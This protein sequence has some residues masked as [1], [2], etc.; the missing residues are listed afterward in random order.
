MAAYNREKLHKNAQ[1]YVASGKIEN[2]I[3]EYEKILEQ[4]PLDQSILNTVGDLY[5]MLKRPSS[6][7]V[8]FLRAAQRLID[9]GFY[10]KAL[11][12]YRKIVRAEPSNLEYAETL[13]DLLVKESSAIEARKQYSDVGAA[14]I[15]A[16]NHTRAFQVYKKLADMSQDDPAP[17]LKL[18]ELNVKQG[19]REAARDSYTMAGN[20]AFRK[21]DFSLALDA[22][23]MALGI[24]ASYASAL[25]ILFKIAAEQKNFSIALAPLQAAAN[26][27]PDAADI[28]EM[29]SRSLM[30]TGDISKAVPIFYRLF[31]QDNNRYPL[32]LELAQA[33]IQNEDLA[34]ASESLQRIG[35]MLVERKEHPRLVTLH[36]AILE[37]DPAYIPSLRALA[38][39]YQATS[40]NFNLLEITENLADAL[41]AAKEHSEALSIL[42][43]LLNWEPQNEKFQRM[44]RDVFQ[45]LY[46]N[47]TYT[48]IGI[49]EPETE[50]GDGLGFLTAASS[51]RLA[52]PVGS[53]GDAESASAIE[54]E[55]F[56]SYGMRDKAKARLLEKIQE[57]PNDVVFRRKLIDLLKEEGNLKEAADLCFELV[58]LYTLK[59]EH[60]RA[61]EVMDEGLYLDPSRSE[62]SL[63]TG[64]LKAGIQLPMDGATA[65]LETGVIDLDEDAIDLTEDLA[66]IFVGEEEKA[67]LP[68]TPASQTGK[69]PSGVSLGGAE[70]FFLLEDLGGEQPA[71]AV[72]PPPAPA[73]ARP[74]KKG[75]GELP[76]RKAPAPS[77]PKMDTD[78]NVR[79]QEAL[80]SIGPQ[81]SGPSRTKAPSPTEQIMSRLSEL[82]PQEE[83]LA[84]EIL[85]EAA[86]AT[87]L[88]DMIASP[89]A[90]PPGEDKFSLQVSLKEADFYIK[91]GF[92]DN[93]LTELNKLLAKYPGNPEILDRIQALSGSAAPAPS[94]PALLEP[95][96]E[97]SELPPANL[98]P[99][100]SMTSEIASADITPEDV[101]IDLFSAIPADSL[102]EE[103]EGPSST[104]EA[105]NLPP[106][107]MPTPPP[108]SDGVFF[109]PESLL[110]DL[111]E[112]EDRTAR[113]ESQGLF[114]PEEE[115]E[116]E[117]S[118]KENVASLHNMFSDIAEEAANTFFPASAEEEG[119]FDT[120]Y[121]MGIVF[122]DMDLYDDA[123]REFQ[124]AFNFVKNAPTTPDFLQTCHMLSFCFAEKG[125]HKS[126]IKW[127][128]RAL[129]TPGHQDHEYMALKYDMAVCYEK[130]GDSL[131][132]MDLYTEIYELDVNYRDV[133]GKINALRNK[134]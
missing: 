60:Q 125:L 69:Q 106:A 114:L 53:T 15:R 68:P 49:Q 54:I 97:I 44:H 83:I 96:M 7:L 63:P 118:S 120:H 85:E 37:K 52:S 127:C 100:L 48:P 39:I 38:D 4:E 90:P 59:G 3:K 86:E 94:E 78:L 12:I 46:P 43:K 66:E 128:E 75:T 79:L 1:K 91:L 99:Q 80:Q 36:Q 22:I 109:H 25:R 88:L 41:F 107:V 47:D 2:A 101:N 122:K 133:S 81:A 30:A 126:A 58:N 14:L 62:A 73:P 16:G 84:P 35:P 87:S 116:Q 9:D 42:E 89:L 10:G 115:A 28:Q 34:A 72:Q 123:I 24:E 17:H 33:A 132:A 121:N 102:P 32:L 119:D 31:D 74:A 21:K 40:D 26:Q 112:A 6:A 29:Y 111:G 20:I 45:A 92:N 67:E 50:V 55:L 71:S 124:Q 13:A 70:D 64:L 113:V 82:P 98:A 76:P 19:A 11:A 104:F 108:S 117:S 56:L 103:F 134:V 77:L 18:A 93:A 129:N 65:V 23:K 95:I 5:T 57:D 61:S 8:Y 130:S 105:R 51:Q 110:E 131:K 27:N